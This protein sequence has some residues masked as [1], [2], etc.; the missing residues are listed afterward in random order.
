MYNEC[1]RLT[2]LK[3]TPPI[4]VDPAM[5]RGWKTAILGVNDTCRG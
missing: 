4:D 1:N 3:K 2:L 5:S